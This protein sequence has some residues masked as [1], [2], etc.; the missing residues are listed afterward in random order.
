MT[1][2]IRV[3]PFTPFDLQQELTKQLK[4]YNPTLLALLSSVSTTQSYTSNYDAHH[5][6]LYEHHEISHV[7]FYHLVSSHIP[8]TFL[9]FS[10]IQIVLSPHSAN[11]ISSI[12]PQS[13]SS[14]SLSS[15]H[16]SLSCDLS[17][18]FSSTHIPPSLFSSIPNLAETILSSLY[19]SKNPPPPLLYNP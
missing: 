4:P 10:T 7:I 3:L 12:Y 8:D 17:P 6:Y 2:S 5:L 13:F 19:L 9:S 18:T 11:F 1:P 16:P 15:T 14:L